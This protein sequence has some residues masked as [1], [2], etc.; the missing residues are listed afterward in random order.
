MHQ[1]ITNVNSKKYKDTLKDSLN[2]SRECSSTKELRKLSGNTNKQNAKCYRQFNRVSM[3]CSVP[4]F[5]DGAFAAAVDDDDDNDDNGTDID[6][7][8][9]RMK[10]S[11]NRTICYSDDEST[12]KC[13]RKSSLSQILLRKASN[14]SKRFKYYMIHS[15]SLFHEDLYGLSWSEAHDILKSPYAV[16]METNQIDKKLSSIKCKQ[17]RRHYSTSV[18]PTFCTTP[19]IRTISRKISDTHS[20]RQHSRLYQLDKPYYIQCKSI[21]RSHST[22][23]SVYPT[24]NWTYQPTSPKNSFHNLQSNNQCT[25]SIE[26]QNQ[27]QVDIKSILKSLT[28][29]NQY[30]IDQSPLNNLN[31]LNEKQFDQKVCLVDEQQHHQQQQIDDLNFN[32]ITIQET[33][34]NQLDHQRRFHQLKSNKHWFT[35]SIEY[36]RKVSRDIEMLNKAT[37]HNVNHIDVELIKTLNDKQLHK[38][39]SDRTSN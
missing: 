8:V 24:H 37:N 11:E 38:S 4:G 21:E 39:L 1:C 26:K 13:K 33:T 6:V 34:D 14:I 5:I 30:S 19:N 2:S 27:S 23:N 36:Q 9:E 32:K 20:L 10:H 17:S 16:S 3:K 15:V 25:K 12:S 28:T 22:K 18:I 7:N 29:N 35:S 31:C